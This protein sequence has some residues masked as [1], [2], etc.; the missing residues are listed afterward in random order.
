MDLLVSVAPSPHL[1]MGGCM[2]HSKYIMMSPWEVAN[3]F[4]WHVP[5]AWDSNGK[6]TKL[7]KKPAHI[8]HYKTDAS[9]KADGQIVCVRLMTMTI[10]PPQ[11]PQ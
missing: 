6:V 1:I 7:E 8:A 2:K 9:S 11:L 5:C 3:T 4:F 10:A